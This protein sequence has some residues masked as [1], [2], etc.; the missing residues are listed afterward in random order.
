MKI[1]D[2]DRPISAA[3]AMKTS[4]VALDRHR[5]ASGGDAEHQQQRREDHQPAQR[6]NVDRVAERGQ[7]DD[8]PAGVFDHAEL[9]GEE[10]HDARSGRGRASCNC[11]RRA[12]RCAGPGRPRRR[13]GRG[14]RRRARWRSGHSRTSK[15][16][17]S[18]AASSSGRSRAPRLERLIWSETL[19]RRKARATVDYQALMAAAARR[20]RPAAAGA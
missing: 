9:V 4:R 16:L 13:T 5:V 3:K 15:N 6:R 1:V 14:Q 17:V 10:G 18:A 8:V 19:G 2:S 20:P 7:I 11:R 12:C